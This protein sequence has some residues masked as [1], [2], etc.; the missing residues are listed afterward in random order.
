MTGFS[1]FSDRQKMNEELTQERD[2]LLTTVEELREK[3]NKATA[4]Q[5]EIETQRDTA[6]ENISQVKKTGG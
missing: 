1:F 2:Q 3:L 4:T 6:S 5:Q